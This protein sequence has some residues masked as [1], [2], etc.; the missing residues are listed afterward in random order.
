MRQAV[1]VILTIIFVVVGIPDYMQ[2]ASP[3]WLRAL[4]YHFYHANIFHLLANCLSIWF[5]FRVTKTRSTLQITKEFCIAFVIASIV[6]TLTHKPVI[7]ISNILFAIAGMRTP[8]FSHPWWK[9]PNTIVFFIV[10][11]LMLL[12]PR[13]AAFT[14]IVSF[15]I[16]V[17]IAVCKRELK[18]VNNDYIRA[19]GK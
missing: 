10:T 19:A 6:F 18:A 2:G 13:F 11:L 4:T 8:A 17:F 5:V 12:L 3:V 14:H 15:A 9:A 1:I 7:G 16:G